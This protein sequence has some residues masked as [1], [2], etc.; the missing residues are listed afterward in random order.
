MLYGAKMTPKSKAVLAF[1]KENFPSAS[2]ALR[3][4]NDFECLIAIVLSAQT[5]DKAVNKVTPMLFAS[6]PNAFSLAKAS[7]E[8]VE[9]IIAPLGL[10]HR[11]AR[12]II[13]LSN[14]LK[15]L[16]EIPAIKEE[17]SLL[18]GVGEKTAG[19]FLIERRNA[20]FIPVD[21]HISRIATRLKYASR[22][23]TSK[24]IEKRLEK[25]FPSREHA[26]IHHA[27]IA[28]GREI[29]QAKNPHCEKC[30]LMGFCSYFKKT[31]STTAR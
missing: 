19:V 18:P 29:C 20:S 12:N 30:K 1:L 23:N 22:K 21:T 24:Q 15:E 25:S 31:S 28:F 2:C 13:A 4:R 11:K 6:F 10:F 16:Q 5:T 7:L 27:L 3:F 9:S 26:F 17:L 14:V 8:E